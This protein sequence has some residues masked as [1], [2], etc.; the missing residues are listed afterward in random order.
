MRG[1]MIRSRVLAITLGLCALGLGGCAV[2]TADGDPGATQTED[3]RTEPAGT[4]ASDTSGGQVNDPTTGAPMNPTHPLTT[5]GKVPPT[6]SAADSVKAQSASSTC[7]GSSCT[8]S[9]SDNSQP[10]P[11]VITPVH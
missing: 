3:G 10:L 11:W 2:Q 7:T 1:F 9:S 4:A 5:N 8:N 6:E